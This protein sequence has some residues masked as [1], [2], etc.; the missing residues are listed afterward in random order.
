MLM[1]PARKPQGTA[2]KVP[3]P[4]SFLPEGMADRLFSA[5]GLVSGHDGPV[6]VVTHYD[7][8]GIAAGAVLFTL[9]RRLDKRVHLSFIKGLS[10]ATRERHGLDEGPGGDEGPPG[11][12]LTLFAD[13]GVNRPDI[14]GSIPGRVIVL[15]HHV[16]TVESPG[17]LVVNCREW[18]IDGSGDASGST[19][20]FLL[21]VAIDEYN[22]DLFDMALVGMMAD[23][24]HLGGLKGLNQRLARSAAGRG[25]VRTYRRLR[26]YEAPLPESLAETFEPLF[27]RFFCEPGNA[28]EF[29]GSLGLDPALTPSGLSE[30]EAGRLGSALAL[31]L[32][33]QGVRPEFASDVLVTG[34]TSRRFDADIEEVAQAV[35]ACGRTG[36]MALGMATCVG[37]SGAYENSLGL[38]SRYREGIRKGLR[39]LMDGGYRTMGHI[40]RF[41]SHGDDF[42][43]A[44]AGLG[45]MY[46]FDPLKPAVSYAAAGEQYKI[47]GRGTKWLVEQKGV[48]LARALFEAASRVGG[49]GGGHPVA[50]G[51]S[52]PGPRLEEFL[53]DVDRIVGEQLALGLSGAGPP[54]NGEGRKEGG[55]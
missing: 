28:G 26:L 29:I 11:D 35:N 24:Q 55:G 1:T 47:S 9:L 42:A 34:Y 38:R 52:I 40:T 54:E 25:A 44:L 7:G 17:A 33:Q 2:V 23:R 36:Q 43:G 8:D 22:W 37:D 13:M 50:S 46:L 27:G 19:M 20:A 30:E 21:A 3:E 15:D 45:M 32:L 31:E 10:D 18:G 12:R 16:G 41:E 6:R 5:A 53:A 49:R 4:L 14:V 48:D 51:A 39:G